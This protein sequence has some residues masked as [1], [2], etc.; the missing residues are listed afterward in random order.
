MSGECICS[1]TSFISP[2][3]PT[4]TERQTSR[5][6]MIYTAQREDL[7]KPTKKTNSLKKG[8]EMDDVKKSKNADTG[9]YL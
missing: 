8:G 9:I 3:S 5:R 2:E 1:R 6:G 7:N 4:I